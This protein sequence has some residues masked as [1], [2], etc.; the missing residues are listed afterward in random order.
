MNGHRGMV[1]SRKWRMLFVIFLPGIMAS[2]M[3]RHIQEKRPITE[4]R[5]I[6]T[7]TGNTTHL[8]WESKANVIYTVMYSRNHGAHA[9]WQPLPGYSHIRGTGST[10]HIEDH[11]SAYE[12]RYYRLQI[13][14]VPQ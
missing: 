9:R 11:P 7:R 3:T 8:Q 13:E 4:A 1:I 12:K 2:C 10:I 14:A 5:W 6:V